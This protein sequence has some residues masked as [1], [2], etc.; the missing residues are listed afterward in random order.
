M[1]QAAEN[2]NAHLPQWYQKWNKFRF[3][4][5]AACSFLGPVSGPL[6]WGVL[7]I[8]GV[9]KRVMEGPGPLERAKQ[10]EVA[11]L[12]KADSTER[13]SAL[14]DYAA[15]RLGSDMPNTGVMLAW[16]IAVAHEK[17]SLWKGN[18]TTV[19]RKLSALA[20]PVL[21]QK[22]NMERRT[23]APF[24]DTVATLGEDSKS[25][26]QRSE[27]QPLWTRLKAWVNEVGLKYGMN[28]PGD[29]FVIGLGRVI[30]ANFAEPVV[31]LFRAVKTGFKSLGSF[32][33]RMRRGGG[34]AASPASIAGSHPIATRATT[35][36]RSRD[37][38][39]R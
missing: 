21:R 20:F 5:V 1:R 19:A 8:D 17:A 28:D 7:L 39:H 11:T 38:Q 12:K 22:L 32:M 30:G 29:P 33:S 13:L 35:Q 25:S 34:E 6:D 2:P 26:W 9:L 10:A 3:G 23:S 16:A 14:M 15:P 37:E 31:K 4:V 27:G 18:S 24:L 36:E